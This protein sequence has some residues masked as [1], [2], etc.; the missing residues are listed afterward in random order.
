MRAEGLLALTAGD[1]VLRILPP[2]IV[3]DAE[4]DAGIDIM[5][6]VAREWPQ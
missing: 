5:R 6:K 4:I 3:T 2:L 1:N